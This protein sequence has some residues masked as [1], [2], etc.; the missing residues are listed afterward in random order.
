MESAPDAGV[1]KE[2]EEGMNIRSKEATDSDGKGGRES[3]DVV[4]RS[5]AVF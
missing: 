4:I 2:G 3:L 1:L 5:S